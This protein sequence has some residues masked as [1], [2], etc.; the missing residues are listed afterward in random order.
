MKVLAL[1]PARGGSKGVPGKNVKV[2]DGKPLI[3]YTIEAAINSQVLND[4]WV[5]SEDDRILDVA[6]QYPKIKIHER[7]QENATDNSPVTDTISEV[8]EKSGDE[9]D[10][11]MILQ[12][13]SPIR[14]GKQIDDAVALLANNQEANSLISVVAMDDI[15]PARMYWKEG[16]N[17]QPILK[18]FEQARRQ[19]IPKAFYRNGS[20]YIVRTEAFKRNHSVMV[21]PSIGYEMPL[22]RLLNIDEPRDLLIAE[23]LIK[24]WQ[25]GEL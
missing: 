17:L 2:I 10:A 15:H 19:D 4:I 11:I 6:R 8:L 20:I 25:K 23:P 7:S 14:D 22:A 5:S 24:A 13:T 3:G 16:D 9:F 1:I 18:Q 21:K 12:V